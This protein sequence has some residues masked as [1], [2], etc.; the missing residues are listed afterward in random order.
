[1]P[2]KSIF[3]CHL[4]VY[5]VLIIIQ[6]VKITAL[7]F[8]KIGTIL[9]TQDGEWDIGPLPDIGGPFDT[10]TQFFEAWVDHVKFPHDQHHILEMMKGQPAQRT[11]EVL[12]AV[13]EFPSQIRAMASRLSQHNDG[14][15]PL[16]HR[17]FIHSNMIV[18]EAFDVIAVIDWEGACTLPQE[19]ICFPDF[20]RATPIQFNPSE[21]YAADGLPKDDKERQRWVEREEYLEMVRAAEGIDHVLSGCLSDEKALALSYSMQAYCNGHLG[22]YDKVIGSLK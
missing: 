7:R 17:D 20:L 12:Q 5:F 2:C 15:F 16:C 11:Q 21:S 4:S 10:A 13:M 6:Q 3:C 9:K 8:P 19:L 14:P 1:M 22:Y 18:N